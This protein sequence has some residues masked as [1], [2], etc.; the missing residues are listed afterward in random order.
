MKNSFQLEDCMKNG[1]K[2]LIKNKARKRYLYN[3]IGLLV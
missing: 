1:K 3:K 2:Y